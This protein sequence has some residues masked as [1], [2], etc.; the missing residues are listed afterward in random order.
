MLRYTQSKKGLKILSNRFNLPPVRLQ[1][2]QMSMLPVIPTRP[3]SLVNS[4]FTKELQR[5]YT[6]KLKSNEILTD[7]I[8]VSSDSTR[9]KPVHFKTESELFNH[10]ITKIPE[11]SN[12]WKLN[13]YIDQ[14]E[15]DILHFPDSCLSLLL[16]CKIHDNSRNV[17]FEALNEIFESMF[18]ERHIDNDVYHANLMKLY[19]S[20]F[21]I[22]RLP[23]NIIY[24]NLIWSKHGTKKLYDDYVL[25]Y[26]INLFNSGQKP[27]SVN[28]LFEHLMVYQGGTRALMEGLPFDFIAYLLETRDFDRLHF[29]LSQFVDFGIRLDDN[30]WISILLTGLQYNNYEIVNFVYKNYIM[31]DFLSGK[32]TLEDA[33][34]NQSTTTDNS[35]FGTFT[36]T[37]ILQILHTISMNGDIKSTEDLVKGHFVYKALSSESS[38][39]RK[40]LCINII[41]SY[42]Y[43]NKNED[44]RGNIHGDESIKRILDLINVFLNHASLSSVDIFDCMNY[45]FKHWKIDSKELDDDGVT[46]V[47]EEGEEIIPTYHGNKNISTSRYGVV[48]ANLSNLNEFIS[49]H[50]NYMNKGNFKPETQTIFINCLLNHMVVFLNHTGM[51]SVLKNLHFIYGDEFIDY[52]DA[53]SWDL[54]LQSVS[55]STSKKCA[56][57]YFEYLKSHN[58]EITPKI[59]S[60]MASASVN[61]N[62][63]SENVLFYVKQCLDDHGELN[64]D[65]QRALQKI[66]SKDI[67]FKEL[68][69]KLQEDPNA[70]IAIEAPIATPAIERRYFEMYDLKELEIL[71]Q[72]FS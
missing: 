54:I 46:K 27:L 1:C 41:E 60:S 33:V 5:L 31:K 66:S 67:R 42:C 23:L 35:V 8:S 14:V 32:L 19:L 70:A 72:I 12:Y 57:F 21:K 39:M 29:V 34:L 37:L 38:A 7:T 52:L 64:H 47:N 26:L 58:I 6:K 69:G 10:I 30:I 44:I 24:L 71:E 62:D 11:F 49:I 50:V 16:E 40:E 43:N 59:Y 36:D 63:Y 56:R 28:Q 65:M 3:P 18:S 20:I 9:L 13:E 68:L 22:N 51:V 4:T 25:T 15:R 53:N 2:S 17:N 55:H 48:L 61:G 45:K